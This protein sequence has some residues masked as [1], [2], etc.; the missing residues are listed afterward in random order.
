VNVFLLKSNQLG[1]YEFDHW[2]EQFLV[3][4]YLAKLQ[5]Y[6]GH[7]FIQIRWIKLIDKCGLLWYHLS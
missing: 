2:L 4:F 5:I 3:K 7:F 1:K 6:K